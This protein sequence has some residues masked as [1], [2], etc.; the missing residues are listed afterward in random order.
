[1]VPYLYLFGYTITV[2]EFSGNYS[3]I[4]FLKL[5]TFA[6]PFTNWYLYW[7]FFSVLREFDDPLVNVVTTSRCIQIVHLS[8]L[9]ILKS[10]RFT[11][12]FAIFVL[13]AIVLGYWMTKYNY[14]SRLFCGFI[15]FKKCVWQSYLLHEMPKNQ[16]SHLRQILR[17]TKQKS[18]RFVVISLSW[19]LHGMSLGQ[20]CF[21][22]LEVIQFS[23]PLSIMGFSEKEC[24]SIVRYQIS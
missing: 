9:Q 24:R 23:G 13:N 21:C 1:M 7:I 20:T 8:T 18:E 15:N 11:N 2:T 19:Y 17:I 22:C 4:Y 10:G 6:L 3:D 14:T 12:D 5:T 16:I